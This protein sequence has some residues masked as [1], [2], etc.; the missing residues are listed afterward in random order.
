MRAFWGYCLACVLG[1][2]GV[3]VLM[4]W[5]GGRVVEAMRREQ[6]IWKAR[7]AEAA[8]TVR[9][10]SVEV[11]K[12]VREVKTLRDSVL[13]NIHDTTVIQEFVY[14]TDTLRAACL[15]CTES[16]S[17]LRTFSDSLNRV[18]DSLIRKLTP[19]RFAKVKG[20]ALFI[21]GAVLGAYIRGK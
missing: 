20:P 5:R 11:V 6:S 21:G 1:A 18:N 4:D 8:S 3:F 7:Y 15:A 12:R 17:R 13:V 19:S 2:V 14:R 16:A 9:V 10:D